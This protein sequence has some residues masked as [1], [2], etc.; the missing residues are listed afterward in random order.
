MN[1]ID[2]LCYSCTLPF[3]LT[4]LS[5]TQ[6]DLCDNS[7]GA[8]L[9]NVTLMCVSPVVICGDN[10]VAPSEVCDD[11][12]AVNGDG[13]SDACTVEVDFVC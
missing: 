10:Y 13:C 4:C 9:N 6:C 2:N 3:C 11:G 8:Y 5:L 1:P 7:T 12:N